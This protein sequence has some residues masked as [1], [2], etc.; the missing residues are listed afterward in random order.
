[1]VRATMPARPTVL[2]VD[3]DP[4]VLELSSDW[5]TDEGV[6]WLTAADPAAGLALLADRDVDCLVSDSLS[7]ADGE[8]FVARAADTVPALSVV[9]FTATDREAVDL[10]T[11]RAAEAH[12]EKGATDP[13]ARLFARVSTLVTDR[14]DANES[15]SAPS[16]TVSEHTSTTPDRR[17]TGNDRSASWV[18]IG[19]YDP[20]TSSPDLATTIVTAVDAYTDRDVSTVAPLYESIDAEVLEALLRRPDGGTRAGIEVRFP[21]AEYE[22]AVTSEG[23][24][25]LRSETA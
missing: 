11:R 8:P 16:E 14:A 5:A 4:A 12:V 6:T 3:D 7:T 2:H 22:L 24:I 25:L 20:N 18:S 19:R 15:A 23:R 17:S 13:F 9:L 21:F 1:M 10:Q